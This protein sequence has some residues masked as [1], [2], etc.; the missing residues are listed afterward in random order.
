[1]ENGK[2]VNLSRLNC[3]LKSTLTSMFSVFDYIFPGKVAV[4]SRKTCTEIVF[5]GETCLDNAA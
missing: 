3:A 2:D 1:M 5:Q 4:D